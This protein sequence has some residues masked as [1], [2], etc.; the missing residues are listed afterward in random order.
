M[1]PDKKAIKRAYKLRPPDQGVYQIR[2]LVNGKAFIGWA[3]DLNGKLNSER[4]QL[5]NGM[6]AN[7]ELQKDFDEL[8]E[9]AFAF[10]V[11]D[12]LAPREGEI[13]PGPELKALEDL[14]LETLRPFGERG[15]HREKS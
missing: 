14:W 6:H 12:R 13:D 10:Q 1:K 2:N 4:F 15:Y 3:M 9:E 11:L 5:R 7:R 8:G